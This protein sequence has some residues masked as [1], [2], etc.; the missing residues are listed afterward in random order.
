M[1]YHLPLVNF[2]YSNNYQASI[3]MAPYEALYGRPCKSPLCWAKPEEHVIMGPQVIEDTIE[4]PTQGCLEPPKNL[5][6]STQ[7][8]S[9]IQCW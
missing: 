2:T 9:G 5:C 1:D 3:S 4:R 8:R 6:G 7:S